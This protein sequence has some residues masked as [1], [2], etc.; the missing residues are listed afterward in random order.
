L[1]EIL[2]VRGRLDR[3]NSRI[4]RVNRVIRQ[5]LPKGV[6]LITNEAFQDQRG[7]IK[8]E[9]VVDGLHLSTQGYELLKSL[10]ER[11]MK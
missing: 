7:D 6:E 4:E 10:I 9:Y 3:D 11:K 5:Y 1:V 2:P 8:V